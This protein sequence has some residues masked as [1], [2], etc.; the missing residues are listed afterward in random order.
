[1]VLKVSEDK[2]LYTKEPEDAVQYI[3]QLD[4]SYSKFA[5]FYDIAIKILPLW[6]SW[7]KSVIPYITLV[8]KRV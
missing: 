2:I 5:K 3:N 1:M 4:Q 7:I 6:K 8:Q